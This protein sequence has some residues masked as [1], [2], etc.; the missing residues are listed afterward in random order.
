[1]LTVKKFIEIFGILLVFQHTKNII[2][3]TFIHENLSFVTLFCQILTVIAFG[4]SSS[5]NCQGQDLR[6]MPWIPPLI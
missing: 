6:D 4:D 5:T 2:Y 1:M 3:I